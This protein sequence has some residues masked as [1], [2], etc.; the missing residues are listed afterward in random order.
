MNEIP[1]RKFIKKYE[2]KD[3]I[4]SPLVEIPKETGIIV[5]MQYP[6]LGMK[7]AIDDCL[8]RKEVLDKLIRAKKYLPKGY[9]FKIWD[10]YR[11]LE[12]QKE[13]YYTYKDKIIKDFKHENLSK[14]KQK[15][16]INKYV[17]FPDKNEQLPP[18][19]STGG[20]IDLTITNEKTGKDLDMGIGFDDFSPLAHTDAF[21]K[22]GMD[23]TIRDNRRLLYNSMTKAG[24]TNLSSE[25]W[26]YDYGDRAWAFYTKNPAKYKGIFK[27]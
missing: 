23:K 19:H 5:D 22:D 6:K 20:A 25:V 3:F 10:A 24:F 17:S 15:E 26:H 1:H 12:L 14:E 7:E 9:T 18:L 2:N 11:P 8:V 4:N 27:K 16:L 13:L 21:E